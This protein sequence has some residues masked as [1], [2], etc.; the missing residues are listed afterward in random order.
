MNPLVSPTDSVR[1]QIPFAPCDSHCEPKA[2]PHIDLLLSP[3][4][5]RCFACRYVLALKVPKFSGYKPGL[6]YDT[7][8]PQHTALIT[9]GRQSSVNGY[10]DV[11]LVA[12]EAHDQVHQTTEAAPLDRQIT[13]SR[14]VGCVSSGGICSDASKGMAVTASSRTPGT[15][16]KQQYH[17][18]LNTCCQPRAGQIRYGN[19]QACKS[20]DKLIL[21]NWYVLHFLLL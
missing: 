11:L 14:C 16:A 9:P 18:T 20:F 5:S 1:L 15:Q 7:A 8:E 10:H 2:R 4:L 3:F 19:F 17:Y 12:G 21:T 6:Y 13:F